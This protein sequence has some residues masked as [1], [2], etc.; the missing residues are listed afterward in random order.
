[1][2]Y[3]FNG[4]KIFHIKALEIF[5]VQ[6]FKCD[7]TCVAK[8]VSMCIVPIFFIDFTIVWRYQL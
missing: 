7:Y 4:I 1:M 6:Y 2:Y 5:M 8:N 3:N